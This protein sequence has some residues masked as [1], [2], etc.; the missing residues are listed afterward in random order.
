MR[1]KQPGLS[2]EEDWEVTHDVAVRRPLGVV[3]SVHLDHLGFDQ[4]AGAVESVGLTSIEFLR[5]A[6]LLVAN[7][8]SL[9]DRVSRSENGGRASGTPDPR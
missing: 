8:P 6:A 4:I 1:N 2:P 3:L 9:W 7:N 5:E